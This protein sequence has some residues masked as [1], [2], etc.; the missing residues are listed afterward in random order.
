MMMFTLEARMTSMAIRNNSSRRD[1]EPVKTGVRAAARRINNVTHRK[2]LVLSRALSE[3]KGKV[4]ILFRS[5]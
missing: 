1:A 4:F 3:A 5:S 2:G